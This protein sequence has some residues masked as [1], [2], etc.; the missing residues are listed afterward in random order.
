MNEEIKM[1]TKNK[2]FLW[3][4]FL[5]FWLMA[6]PANLM[7]ADDPSTT[8][9]M[10]NYI[11]FINFV[12]L[13]VPVTIITAIICSYKNVK[14][15]NYFPLVYIMSFFFFML[16]FP[17]LTPLYLSG[18]EHKENIFDLMDQDSTWCGSV[19]SRLNP[20]SIPET[21]CFVLENGK[22]TSG[23]FGGHNIF[24]SR[25]NSG[26]VEYKLD[27][28]VLKYEYKGDYVYSSPFVQTKGTYSWTFC[29][30]KE[31]KNCPIGIDFMGDSADKNAT[32][33]SFAILRCTK[34]NEI[35]KGANCFYGDDALEQV[36]KYEK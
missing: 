4:L 15:A 28:T 29:E 30:D 8:V 13:L 10:Y 33:S 24:I 5:P 27:G 23:N 32:T 20:I 17:F 22:S 34:R 3:L 2:V 14:Y 7:M 26:E 12:W 21:G 36:K 6:I 35:Q 16:M 18:G 11:L 25:Y 1:K 31:H 9:R 19:P